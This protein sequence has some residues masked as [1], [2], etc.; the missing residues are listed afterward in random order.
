MLDL[1]RKGVEEITEL[2]KQAILDADQASVSDLHD[3]PGHF[4]RS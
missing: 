2:Q 4:K 1:A 3:L